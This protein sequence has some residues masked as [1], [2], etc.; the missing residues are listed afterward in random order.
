[1][2]QFILDSCY[3]ANVS[4][5]DSLAAPKK[6]IETEQ[7]YL[8]RQ[9]QFL[10]RQLAVLNKCYSEAT[11]I[12]FAQAREADTLFAMKYQEVEIPIDEIGKYDDKNFILPLKVNGQWYDVKLPVQDAQTLI[13]IFK[14]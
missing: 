1:M 6:L 9:K 14:I 2:N 12:R 3:N 7:Q 10:A 13:T 5:F 8:A 4:E 11:K